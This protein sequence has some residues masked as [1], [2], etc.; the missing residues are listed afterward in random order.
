MSC[1]EGRFVLESHSNLAAGMAALGIPEEDV[2]KLMDPKNHV[3][4]NVTC[5]SPG[6]FEVT[7]TVSLM[8]EW[9]QTNSLKLGEK[10]EV[11]SPIPSSIVLTKKSDNVLIN[12]T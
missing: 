11:T 10:L 3:E 12:R 8:P 6:C 4:Y 2:K 5:S 1:F 9:N 7:S